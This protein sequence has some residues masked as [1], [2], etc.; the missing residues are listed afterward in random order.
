[1]APRVPGLVRCVGVVMLSLCVAPAG[2]AVF[3]VGGD[4][5]CTH[6]TLQAAIDAAIAGGST[7][8]IEVAR[9]TPHLAQAMTIAAAPQPIYIRGGYADPSRAERR[10]PRS[11]GPATLPPLSKARVPL[12]PQ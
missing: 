8:V 5:A 6:A 12:R 1:M 9:N 7:G 11:A 10:A 3:K 4:A 2:A